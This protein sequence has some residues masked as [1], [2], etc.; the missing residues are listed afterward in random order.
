MKT[1]E[2]IIYVT[3]LIIMMSLMSCE[4]DED[5]TL[6][7]SVNTDYVGKWKTSSWCGFGAHTLDIVES[8]DNEVLIYGYVPATVYKD[9][10]HTVDIKTVQGNTIT[11]TY[12]GQIQS[13]GTLDYREKIEWS[14]QGLVSDCDANFSK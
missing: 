9:S 14:T 4:T 8:S 3:V 2:I 12:W 5:V 7:S 11:T 1:Q 13:D 6:T 10:I